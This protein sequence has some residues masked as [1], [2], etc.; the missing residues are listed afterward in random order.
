MNRILSLGFLGALALII[1]HPTAVAATYPTYG[2]GVN[3]GSEATYGNSLTF[4][5]RAYS[6]GELDAGI[7]Y[8]STGTKIGFGNTFIFNPAR[9]FGLTFGNALIYSGGTDGEVEVDAEFTPEG[10]SKK[11]KL[12]A[13][14]SYELSPAILLGFAAGGYLDYWS[15]LR[16]S[17]KLTYNFPIW[18]NKVT[19]GDKIYY[20]P[21]VEVANAEEF[22]EEFEREAK[23]KVRAGGLGVQMGAAIVF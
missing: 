11:E 20:E 16:L 2:I 15:F 8:N 13:V 19:T 21:D 18:G 22:D 17:A 14:K 4:S 9:Y 12:T 3:V 1:M 23:K 7:G 10:S 6:F 5:W